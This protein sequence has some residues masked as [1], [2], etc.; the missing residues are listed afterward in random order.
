M[1]RIAALCFG[2]VLQA[3]AVEINLNDIKPGEKATGNA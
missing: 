1:K 2:V 3:S